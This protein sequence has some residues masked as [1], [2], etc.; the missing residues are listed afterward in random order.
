MPVGNAFYYFSKIVWD[1]IAPS[2]FLELLIFVSICWATTGSRRARFAAMASAAYAATVGQ[3]V[4][5]LDDAA[6]EWIGLIAYRAF[7]NTEALF[8]TP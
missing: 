1:F 6:R 7:N 5:Q 3:R 8:P 2:R 4:S